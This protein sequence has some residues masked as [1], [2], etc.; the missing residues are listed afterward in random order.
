MRSNA[1]MPSWVSA[2]RAAPATP[3]AIRSASP[4]NRVSVSQATAREVCLAHSATAVPLPQPDGALTL[5]M[6]CVAR[7]SSIS[8]TTRTRGIVP[9]ASGGVVKNQGERGQTESAPTPGA[10]TPSDMSSS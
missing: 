7:A 8:F 1:A 10:R 5:T 3:S 9:R 2:R 6:R 4:S